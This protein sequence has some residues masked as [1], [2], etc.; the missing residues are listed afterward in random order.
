MRAFSS[1]AIP[2]W[3][4]A[5]TAFWGRSGRRPQSRSRLARPGAEGPDDSH[6]RDQAY[7]VPLLLPLVSFVEVLKGLQQAEQG[8]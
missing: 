2:L 3:A 8:R 7:F 5:R 6:R 1:W 4:A